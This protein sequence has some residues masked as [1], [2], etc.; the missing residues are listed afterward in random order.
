[1]AEPDLRHIAAPLRPL[2]RPIDTFTTWPGNPRR[3]DLARIAESLAE[4]GQMS[5][6]VVQASSGHIAAGNHV[7]RAARDLL[8]WTHLAFSVVEMDDE[9]ARAYVLSDNRLSDLAVYDPAA[10]RALLTELDAADA[11]AGTGFTR[12]ELNAMMLDAPS[13]EAAPSGRARGGGD[14]P[15]SEPEAWDGPQPRTVVLR[16]SATDRE[17]LLAACGRLRG[18]FSTA[19]TASTV[20]RAL[21]RQVAP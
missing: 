1:M 8:G 2:A 18:A 15:E 6:V 17:A 20:L 12:D 19:S 7:T 13:G 21:E 4:F 10:L 14:G 9:T 16:Y 5:P 3:G 11:M